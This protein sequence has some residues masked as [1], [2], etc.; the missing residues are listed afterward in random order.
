MS[1]PGTEG[2]LAIPKAG[3]AATPPG[4]DKGY[5]VVEVRDVPTDTAS[6]AAER[7]WLREEKFRAIIFGAMLGVFVLELTGLFVLLVTG[8]TTVAETVELWGAFGTPVATL[9]GLAGA[10][11]Y[12]RGAHQN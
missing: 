6:L 12:Y 2:G 11:Y 5:D 10:H 8:T 9:L 3:D 4:A 7:R 1:G